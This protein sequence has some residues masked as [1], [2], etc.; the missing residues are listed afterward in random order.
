MS[1]AI[2]NYDFTSYHLPRG[3]FK[4]RKP[5]DYNVDEDNENS[6]CPPSLHKN[7]Y[8]IRYRFSDKGHVNKSF[9]LL[10][11]L[12][13]LNLTILINGVAGDDRLRRAI[14]ENV[15]FT[16]PIPPALP[17]DGSKYKYNLF[18]DEFTLC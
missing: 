5:P 3:Y 17:N 13:T 1:S 12:L 16:T 6:A 7:S 18:F 15:M 8:S 11:T 10:C 14:E 4:R 2:N 9:L